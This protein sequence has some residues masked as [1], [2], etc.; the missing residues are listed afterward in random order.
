MVMRRLIALI[1]ILLITGNPSVYSQFGPVGGGTRRLPPILKN[2]GQVESSELTGEDNDKGDETLA[3]S[4]APIDCRTAANTVAHA[5]EHPSHDEAGILNNW[6]FNPTE[7]Q[8]IYADRLSQVNAQ[9]GG[10]PFHDFAGS[11]VSDDSLRYLTWRNALAPDHIDISTQTNQ[12][13][14]ET[15]TETFAPT[16]QTFENN[17]LGNYAVDSGPSGSYQLNPDT[18]TL[19]Q[20]N[21]SRCLVLINAGHSYQNQIM[22]V[23]T[24]F[25]S[26]STLGS[27]SF[28]YSMYGISDMSHAGS[29]S[30][31]VREGNRNIWTR[32]I[33]ADN[34]CPANLSQGYVFCSLNNYNLDLSQLAASHSYILDFNFTV[35]DDPG[36]HEVSLDDIQFLDTNGHEYGG[37]RRVTTQ[38]ATPQTT[39]YHDVFTEFTRISG[40]DKYNYPLTRFLS[41]NP[42][43]TAGWALVV[44]TGNSASLTLD[45]ASSLPKDAAPTHKIQVNQGTPFNKSTDVVTS[46]NKKNYTGSQTLTIAPSD[47]FSYLAV[48]SDHKYFSQNQFAFFDELVLAFDKA[49]PQLRTRLFPIYNGVITTETPLLLYFNA[50]DDLGLNTLGVMKQ[51]TQGS[52]LLMENAF[53]TAQ[54]DLPANQGEKTAA[55]EAPGMSYTNEPIKISNVDSHTTG[56]QVFVRDWVRDANG[57]RTVTATPLP[58]NVYTL[59]DKHVECDRYVVRVGDQIQCRKPQGRTRNTLVRVR[60]KGEGG[61]T[62]FREANPKADFYNHTTDLF[63]AKK[64]GT[65]DLETLFYD[66]DPRSP[67]LVRRST[68]V[69]RIVVEKNDVATPIAARL[70]DAVAIVCLP[71]VYACTGSGITAFNLYRKNKPDYP[72][73]TVQKIAGPIG[74]SAIIE[75]C[76]ADINVIPDSNPLYAIQP[77]FGQTVG[78][79]SGW[80]KTTLVKMK[81]SVRIDHFPLPEKPVN[82]EVT[83]N[84]AGTGGVMSAIDASNALANRITPQTLLIPATPDSALAFQNIP[85]PNTQNTDLFV[86]KLLLMPSFGVQEA[87]M[88]LVSTTLRDPHDGTM[89]ALT[90][91]N[92]LLDADGHHL[93][94]QSFWVLTGDL[95]K[96]FSPQQLSKALTLVKA[97]QPSLNLAQ[98]AFEGDAFTCEGKE[99]V[100]GLKVIIPTPQIFSA[101]AFSQFYFNAQNRSGLLTVT[102]WKLWCEDNLDTCIPSASRNLTDLSGLP[103]DNPATLQ[104]YA[105][106]LA[107]LNA[108]ELVNYD[109]QPGHNLFKTGSSLFTDWFPMLDD[110][111]YNRLI[112]PFSLD[113]PAGPTTMSDVGF[114]YLSLIRDTEIAYHIDVFPDIAPNLRDTIKLFSMARIKLEEI[115]IFGSVITFLTPQ[116]PLWSYGV[117][118]AW[119][120][121]ITSGD[122]STL[123][124]RQNK[125]YMQDLANRLPHIQTDQIREGADYIL[126]LL[127]DEITAHSWTSPNMMQENSRFDAAYI[128]PNQLRFNYDFF[129]NYYS[130]FGAAY[131]H[132]GTHAANDRQFASSNPILSNSF[133]RTSTSSYKEHIMYT[134]VNQSGRWSVYTELRAYWNTRIYLDKQCRGTVEEKERAILEEDILSK[135]IYQISFAALKI[136]SRHPVGAQ[137]DCSSESGL[138]RD[139]DFEMTSIPWTPVGKTSP[140]DD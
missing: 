102:D 138:F 62:G 127:Q 78:E 94:K 119:P 124:A 57:F 19:A 70:S 117:G 93:V 28:K 99:V 71:S 47:F 25:T 65:Y 17:T 130:G 125:R 134:L 42:Y 66:N 121:E 55:I 8:R 109:A 135:P 18:R 46:G 100:P 35:N 137:S 63:T 26:A 67:L 5:L 31:T 16:L 74:A 87:N 64:A 52:S 53:A 77:I 81:P 118:L 60:D 84:P 114:A 111:F 7:L 24:A 103:N 120:D 20:C 23:T 27:V 86:S 140:W 101:H 68:K 105:L 30:V 72:E 108:M 43:G 110:Y 85:A 115:P 12:T 1:G 37:P 45:F 49:A 3:A 88:T 51:S 44:P 98:C 91:Y 2:A 48:K 32:L 54:N 89:R 104:P 21:G 10:K 36:N 34:Q 6:R 73:S 50:S 33:Q 129:D 96:N 126:H 113:A 106:S 95:L 83:W 132:E 75:N 107:T 61:N 131:L 40:S 79:R 80:D 116:C 58:F 4:V 69:A 29:L 13:A 128:S 90:D 133:W 56:F 139:N 41:G 9:N 97:L 92:N 11:S 82:I 136:C 15:T 22:H 38:N 76:F 112:L 39:T 123:T 59:D 122:S 14:T